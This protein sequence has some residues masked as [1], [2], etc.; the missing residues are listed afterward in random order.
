MNHYF[1][2]R[3]TVEITLDMIGVSLAYCTLDESKDKKFL[4]NI[5]EKSITNLEVIP[6]LGYTSICKAYNEAIKESKNDTIILCHNDVNILTNGF[7]KIIYDL[8]EKH[9]KYGVIGVVGSNVWDRSGWLGKGGQSI[10]TLVQYNKYKPGPPKYILFSPAFR[11][12]DLVPVCTVDGMFIAIRRDRIKEK[13]DEC[14]KGFHFYDVMFAVDNMMSDVGVGV[15]YSLD[16]CHYSDGYL[17]KE[18]YECKTFADLKYQGK[19]YHIKLP[20]GG[21]MVILPYEGDISKIKKQIGY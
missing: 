1:R 19:N 15:T 9:P 2:K 12:N 11:N 7:D 21:K 5:N 13:F 14:L 4:D 3:L 10:G 8:F 18:W 20:D 6:K 16:I 17:S